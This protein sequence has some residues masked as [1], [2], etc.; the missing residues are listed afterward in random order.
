[1]NAVETDPRRALE[2]SEPRLQLLS[3]EEASRFPAPGKWS[4]KQ[5]IGHLIDSA[6]NNHQRFVRA[7][8]T[9]DLVFPGYEQDAW[10]ST[11]RYQEAS[12]PDLVRLW[13][14]FNL[15]LARVIEAI[16]RSVREKP[17][18]RHNLHELAWRPVAQSDAATLEYFIRDY[19]EHLKHHLAQ[20]LER[21]PDHP[22]RPA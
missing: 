6:S 1:M 22:R 13:H 17:R 21:P 8:F 16:P 3:E 7:Q 20:V 11:Q 12:W 9:E 10:V 19:V 18:T 4:A 2:S 5:V 14:L 15:H